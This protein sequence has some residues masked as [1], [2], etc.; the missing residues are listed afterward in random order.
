MKE[1]ACPGGDTWGK[2]IIS[3][4]IFLRASGRRGQVSRLDVVYP[5]CQSRPRKFFALRANDL[6]LNLSV[7]GPLGRYAPIPSRISKNLQMLV[8]AT[9]PGSCCFTRLRAKHVTAESLRASAFC[10]GGGRGCP[11]PGGAPALF[12]SCMYR[13]PGGGRG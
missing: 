5:I 2:V 11:G 13:C 7:W 4:Q 9:W 10:P 3:R 12:Y 1:R 8:F 6:G